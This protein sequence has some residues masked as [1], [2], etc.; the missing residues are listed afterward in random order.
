MVTRALRACVR[1]TLL[2]SC[3]A[4]AGCGRAPEAAPSA[5][6]SV[7]APPAPASVAAPL[8][9]AQPEVAAPQPS[10]GPDGAPSFPVVDA[11]VAGDLLIALEDGGVVV[12][13]R[14]DGAELWRTPLGPAS[15]G[16]ELLLRLPGA[17]RVLVRRPSGLVALDLHS[18]RVAARHAVELDDRLYLWARDGACGLRGQCSMQLVDCATGRPI[19]APITGQIHHER[20]LDGGYSSG[21]WGFAVDLVGRAD[22]VVVHLGRGEG[23][24]AF[25]V[26]ARDG[27]RVWSS[28]A[29]SCR[30][31]ANERFGMSS[32]GAWCFTA[33]D[34]ALV[35][36]ACRTGEVRSTRRVPG[37][38]RA[39]WTG[40]ERGGIF[41]D[42]PGSA[43]LLE[44]ATGAWRW[45]VSVPAD[46][47]AVPQGARLTALA[48]LAYR[49]ER[50]TPLLIL[51]DATGRVAVRDALG[52]D[53]ALTTAADG[54]VAV[55]R[56]ESLYDH[57]GQVIP[58][59]RP[60]P[61]TVEREHLPAGSSGPPNHA[62]VRRTDG[63]I[64]ASLAFDAWPLGWSRVDGDVRLAVMVAST[65]RAVTLYRCG[66]SAPPGAPARE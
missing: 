7:A 46:A 6:A 34:D 53:R 31:C 37:M 9:P 42:T 15:P 23:P 36:F 22:D 48:E 54:S 51:A 41:V 16:A 60:A 5:P 33:E 50:S 65:P 43:A 39:L 17:E 21:C 49:Q 64:L 40:D 32:G 30:Y 10:P 14:L 4:S 13:R 61:A 38:R 2:G 63:T 8:A 35:V 18:G 11:I 45:R 58:S 57:T 44:P 3:L 56:G 1:G 47:L 66:G 20:D 12:A 55:A 52:P 25:G 29:I 26:R 62:V 28:S 19:G 24:T 27:A 59:I